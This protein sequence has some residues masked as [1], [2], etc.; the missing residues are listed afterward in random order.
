MT[1][2][3]DERWNGPPPRCEPILCDPPTPVPHSYIQIDEIDETETM[4][5]KS[6]FN[7]SLLVGSIVTYTCE[8]NYRL[9]GHRQILCLPSGLYDHIAPTCIGKTDS[10]ININ[11]EFL[12]YLHLYFITHKSNLLQQDSTWFKAS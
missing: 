4:P 11:N 2:D 1:C 10:F 9:T 8:K 3:I 12:K 6:S 7:R 5:S